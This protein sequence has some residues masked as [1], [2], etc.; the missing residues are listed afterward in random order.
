LYSEIISLKANGYNVNLKDVLEKEVSK[1]SLSVMSSQIS[2]IERKKINSIIQSKFSL[3]KIT[4]ISFLPAFFNQIRKKY[5]LGK[6]F[7]FMEFSG[8]VMEFGIYQDNEIV[9]IISLETGKNKI[10]RSLVLNNLAQ[11]ISDG[12]YILTLYLDNKLEKKIKEKVKK[13]IESH[14]SQIKEIIFNEIKNNESIKIPKR[15]FI[16]SSGE[17]DYLVSTM[18]LFKE[19]YFM[20]SLFLKNFVEFD[21]QK[22][23]NNFL[24]M[25]TDFIF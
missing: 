4:N 12:E 24:A 19:N 15:V 16:I 17:M 8:E 5:S 20:G 18:D 7:A 9:S 6:N 14:L 1:I 13:I 23:F 11:S 2:I 10:V 22:Y 3:V 25:E 21:E